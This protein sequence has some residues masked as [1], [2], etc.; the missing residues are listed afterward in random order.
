MLAFRPATLLKRDPTQVSSC[1][2]CQDFKNSF[3]IEHLC[4]LLL[5][6]L[7]AVKQNGN[8]ESETT[9]F[10][11]F[12]SCNM[13]V[14][15]AVDQNSVLNLANLTGKHL[16]W[17][18]CLIKLQARIEKRLQH[19][20]FPVKFPRFSRTTAHDCFRRLGKNGWNFT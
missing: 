1:E 2:H 18:L 13:G 12:L 7:M 5:N 14:I 11:L 9:T 8:F 4:W 6:M 19:R 10:W 20:C 3:F 16:C 17:S 15:E